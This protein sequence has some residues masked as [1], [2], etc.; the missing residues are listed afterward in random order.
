LEI[1]RKIKL[2]YIAIKLIIN[3]NLRES[4]NF[5]K[6]LKAYRTKSMEVKK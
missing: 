6:K 1:K 2:L 4:K 5:A 3:K